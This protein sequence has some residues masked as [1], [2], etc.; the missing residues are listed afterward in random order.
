LIT[1]IAG[2]KRDDAFC[3]FLRGFGRRIAEGGH[4]TLDVLLSVYTCGLIR[5]RHVPHHGPTLTMHLI[6]ILLPVTDNNGQH[7]EAA[8]YAQVR[9]ELTKHFGGVTAFTRAP[10]QGSN[11]AGG[12]VVHDDIVVMEVMAANLDPEW[13]AAYRKQLERD[14][15]QDE[16]VIR[17]SAI[18]RL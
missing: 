15:V 16:I 13:W 14:F 7:F 12:T 2:G 5:M 4:K 3:K 18:T 11:A 8:M 1:F 6:E 10:A 9:E 17:A